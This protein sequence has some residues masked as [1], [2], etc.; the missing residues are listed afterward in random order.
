[1]VVVFGRAWARGRVRVWA[2]GC[3]RVS[4]VGAGVT[5]GVRVCRRMGVLVSVFFFS[6]HTCLSLD[7]STTRGT[8]PLT[9]VTARHDRIPFADF[10]PIFGDFFCASVMC[11]GAAL[12]MI[13]IPEYVSTLQGEGAF[14]R[15]RGRRGSMSLEPWSM[16]C[17]L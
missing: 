6:V 17:L 4:F 15:C 12:D 8:V 11:R 1:M 13:E 2:R 5:M 9:S 10:F 14:D 3:G 7:V 16:R